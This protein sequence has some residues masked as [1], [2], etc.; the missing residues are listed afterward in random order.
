MYVGVPK[1]YWDII[2][3][4]YRSIEYIAFLRVLAI[5]H[6][7][8]ILPLWWLVGNCEHL[9]K[10]DL[11]VA[12]MMDVVDLMDKAFAKIQREGKKIMEYVFMFRIFNKIDK[13]GEAV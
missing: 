13:K 12:D 11:G 2:F 9:S 10:W 4:I 7:T 3:I 8:I 6:M 5:L 1:V